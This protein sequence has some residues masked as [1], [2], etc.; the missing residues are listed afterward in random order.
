APGLAHAAGERAAGGPGGH[1]PRRWRRRWAQVGL[2][3]WADRLPPE[4]GPGAK[5]AGGDWRERWC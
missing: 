3:E 5:K 4:L 1:R 2:V